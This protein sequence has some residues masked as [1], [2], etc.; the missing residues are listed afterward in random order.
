MLCDFPRLYT[1]CGYLATTNAV[2]G[3]A[4]TGRKGPK[5]QTGAVG[6]AGGEATGP[7][8]R[9]HG[10]VDDAN[11]GVGLAG[12]KP[13]SAGGKAAHDSRHLG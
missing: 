10:G 13:A 8:F 9:G 4:R 1:E 3:A 12:R 2:E 11:R 7:W 5:G 6:A